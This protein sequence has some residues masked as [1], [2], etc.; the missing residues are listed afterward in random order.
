MICLRFMNCLPRYVGCPAAQD[1]M[2]VFPDLMREDLFRIRTPQHHHSFRLT[3]RDV[4]VPCAD[5]FEERPAL[6][7]E[8]VGCPGPLLRPLESHVY[9]A[10]EQL[11]PG[12]PEP[13]GGPVVDRG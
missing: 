3:P 1:P 2:D 10:V 5:G 6:R 11:G 7:L 9:R 8:P 12:G 13:A 4:Q